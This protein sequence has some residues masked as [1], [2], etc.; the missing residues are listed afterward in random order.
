M[1]PPSLAPK[2][3]SWGLGGITYPR[4][5]LSASTLQSFLTGVTHLGAGG[6]APKSS[7]QERGEESSGSWSHLQGKVLRAQSPVAL[8]SVGPCTPLAG[9]VCRGLG[10]R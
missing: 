1:V 9:C 6:G 5:D 10:E 7:A 4:I 2:Q 3:S 8:R